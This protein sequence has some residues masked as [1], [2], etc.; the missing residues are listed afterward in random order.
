EIEGVQQP[1]DLP[2]AAFVQDD[3]EPRV[4]VAC[5]QD[6]DGFRVEVF[7]V[8]FDAIDEG[9]ERVV[10]G[11]TVHLHVV[12]LV[13]AGRRIGDAGGPGGVVRE[14]QQAF[15]RLVE[16]ADGG[17]PRQAGVFET[18]VDGVAIVFVARG[19]DEAAG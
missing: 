6:V 12:A 13:G 2:V 14:Q 7:A 5:A 3:I 8:G 17:D 16:A 15:A 4:P 18:L 19:G 9:G 11:S 10:V 1:A